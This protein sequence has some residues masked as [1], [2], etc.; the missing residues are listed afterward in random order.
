MQ[1][2]SY[3]QS[4]FDL[5][6]KHKVFIRQE[7]IEEAVALPDSVKKRG[8]FYFAKRDGIGVVYQ[9]ENDTK[10]VVTFYPLKK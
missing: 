1:L 7:Q 6:N 2:S 8:K 3:A 5:L 10:K 9:I 4:K